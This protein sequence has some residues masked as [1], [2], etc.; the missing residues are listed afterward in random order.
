MSH[1]IDNPEAVIELEWCLKG[2]PTFPDFQ[3]DA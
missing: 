2:V 1:L 3:P